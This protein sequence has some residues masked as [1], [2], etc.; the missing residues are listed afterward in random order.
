MD[1]KEMIKHD[2]ITDALLRDTNIY[3]LRDDENFDESFK[4]YDTLNGRV[5]TFW[6][7]VRGHST[8]MVK[9]LLRIS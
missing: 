5:L 2:L 3:P 1:E 8:K 9:R 6:Y 4:E 7:N